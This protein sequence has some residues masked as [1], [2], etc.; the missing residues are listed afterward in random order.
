MSAQGNITDQLSVVGAYTY[1]DARF[2]DNVSGTVLAG[3]RIPNVPKHAASLWARYNP[4]KPLGFALGVIH[5]GRRLAATDNL[6]SMAG[7]TRVDGAIYFRITDKL[8]AQLN[9][10]NI[11]NE[12]YSLFSNSNTNVTPGSPTAFKVGLNARF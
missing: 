1:S 7:Y 12:R 8:D 6:V 11:F 5:Q 10:E 3:N 4:I 9:V 2:L